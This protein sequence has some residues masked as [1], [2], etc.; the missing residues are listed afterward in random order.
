VAILRSLG[1]RYAQGFY[2]SRPVSADRLLEAMEDPVL[3][4]AGQV[5]V[6]QR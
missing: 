5:R 4:A 2:F 6:I 3:P 1:C